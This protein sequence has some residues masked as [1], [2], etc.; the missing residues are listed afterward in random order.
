MT[1]EWYNNLIDKLNNKLSELKI[2]PAKNLR[3]A[4]TKNNKYPIKW[5]EILGDIYHPLILKYNDKVIRTLP[6]CI[7][8]NYM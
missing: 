3:D 6:M 5:T 8:N 4:N 7:C 1:T 2:Y